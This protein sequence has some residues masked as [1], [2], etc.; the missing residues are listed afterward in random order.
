MAMSMETKEKFVAILSAHRMQDDFETMQSWGG[1]RLERFYHQAY[2]VENLEPVGEPV[3]LPFTYDDPSPQG[4]WA[5]HVD[6]VVYTDALFR[7]VFIV[8]IEELRSRRS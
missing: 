7:K 5:G 3:Y 1:P 4:M 2:D 8:D 6:F